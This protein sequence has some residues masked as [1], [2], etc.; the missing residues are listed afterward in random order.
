M[1]LDGLF[2]ETKERDDNLTAMRMPLTSGMTNPRS[3]NVT[4]IN[5]NAFSG[6]TDITSFIVPGG[7]TEIGEFAFSYCTKLSS[8]TIPNGVK[9]IGKG[10]FRG[11]NSLTS[12][13]IP[14]TVTEI[15]EHAFD[16]CTAL[17]SIV[18]PTG[19]KRIDD[20][21]FSC[22]TGLTS[23]VIPDGVIEIG[24]YAFWN[25]FKLTSVTIPE[26]VKIIEEQA[27][28]GC[29]G[30]ASVVITTATEIREHSFGD[31]TNI[32]HSL[33]TE[34]QGH[35]DKQDK[36]QQDEPSTETQF[37]FGLF[38]SHPISTVRISLMIKRIFG[39]SWSEAIKLYQFAPE[40]YA[41][42]NLG[43]NYY[44]GTGIGKDMVSAANWFRL[45]AEQGHTNS[46]FWLGFCYLNGYGVKKDL[47][48]AAIWFRNVAEQGRADAQYW[49]GFCYL[50]SSGT[51]NYTDAE[52]IMWIKKAA[53]Q[54]YSEA[55]NWLATAN[56]NNKN[57]K[58]LGTNP[59]NS[60]ST[61]SPPPNNNYP[62]Y[63]FVP[64]NGLKPYTQ[65]KY[66]VCSTHLTCACG[67]D[68]DYFESMSGLSVHCPSCR[69]NI[70]FPGQK[71]SIYTAKDQSSFSS[72]NGVLS[73]LDNKNNKH[74]YSVQDFMPLIEKTYQKR[75]TI[76]FLVA[77]SIISVAIVGLV[78]V[79][80]NLVLLHF[81]ILL[82]GII[83]PIVSHK[84]IAYDIVRDLFPLLHYQQSPQTLHVF[85]DF[86]SFFL[87]SI[88][89]FSV[90]E[91]QNT[92][93]RFRG[94]K[95]QILNSANASGGENVKT[96]I[97]SYQFGSKIQLLLFP[98]QAII[99]CYGSFQIIGLRSIEL[100]ITE[101]IL[102][103]S[104]ATDYAYYWYHERKDGGPDRR[105]KYNFQTQK[106]CRYGSIPVQLF[107]T[108]S[109]YNYKLTIDGNCFE[110]N[111]TN[112]SQ[113]NPII[114][115]WNNTS[116]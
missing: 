37:D 67:Q 44:N 76:D 55:Q 83:L 20:C 7:V 57:A 29:T 30:L 98:D 53:A 46:Q 45:A 113:V 71:V 66:G 1:D 75:K 106:P 92:Q 51:N 27:F 15:G 26:S 13:V 54:G 112:E 68:I 21:S 42:Y 100:N 116:F 8:I 111:N 3:N 70:Q 65:K 64:K 41:Q 86:L 93:N 91:Q 58:N 105:Y 5:A 32:Q 104:K 63:P 31:Y 108:V 4:K 84:L 22:C 50:N 87:D 61:T 115:R 73:F 96:M 16:A 47:S 101:R 12:V 97:L 25:C 77:A 17:T 43:V 23:V 89:T 103:S 62:K 82:A 59:A 6:R 74:I 114:S 52:A 48:E 33:Q 39:I 79:N 49:L 95:K 107:S 9:T 11:C 78:W 10:A 38:F 80:Q 60:S 109:S 18:I 40:T 99:F 28:G 72:P 88:K 14:K 94:Y 24:K 2:R 36:D 102:F 69:R 81:V 110:G 56:S 19:M 85:E 35:L 90:H 34:Q